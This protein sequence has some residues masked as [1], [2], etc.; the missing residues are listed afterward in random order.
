MKRIVF[1]LAAG[2]L[3]IAAQAQNISIGTGGTVRDGIVEIQGEHRERVAELLA[4]RGYRVR[5]IGG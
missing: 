3:A 5:R 2:S 1:A 4:A